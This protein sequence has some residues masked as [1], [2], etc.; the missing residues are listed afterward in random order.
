M[1]T[2]SSVPLSTAGTPSSDSSTLE[3]NPTA[4]LSIPTQVHHAI[5]ISVK[6]GY[7][8]QNVLLDSANLVLKSTMVA[9]QVPPEKHILRM[10]AQLAAE[11]HLT[12]EG[13][14]RE[15]AVLYSMTE[16]GEEYFKKLAQ[17]IAEQSVYVLTEGIRMPLGIV[18][19]I[20]RSYEVVMAAVPEK[21][22]LPP[23][24][25]P[26][27]GEIVERN[28]FN[29]VFSLNVADRE[30]R[31]ALRFP[32]ADDTNSQSIRKPNYDYNVFNAF[33]TFMTL[34]G[35]QVQIVEQETDPNLLE[36]GYYLRLAEY[37]PQNPPDSFSLVRDHDLGVV[38][39]IHKAKPRNQR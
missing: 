28:F 23:Q 7:R 27:I 6:R 33:A 24:F 5:L 3:K 15:G 8:E 11:G 37:D 9:S 19:N 16:R 4:Y 31:V 14:E 21:V 13:I 26:E 34:N 39:G 18:E 25:V 2:P 17:H 36:E 30:Q 22:K 35:V 29:I 20:F 10:I 38:L 12:K 1:N 32:L